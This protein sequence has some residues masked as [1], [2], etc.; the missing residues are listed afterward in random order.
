MQDRKQY[1]EELEQTRKLRAEFDG[2]IENAIVE[3]QAALKAAGDDCLREYKALRLGA[4]SVNER[5]LDTEFSQVM[6]KIDWL[7]TVKQKIS[8]LDEKIRDM[9]VTLADEEVWK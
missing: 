7:K 1:R 9:V 8:D 3:L 5:W 6:A 4:S 2:H